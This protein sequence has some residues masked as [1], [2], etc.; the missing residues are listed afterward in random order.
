MQGEI[1]FGEIANTKQPA[2]ESGSYWRVLER[3]KFCV[4]VRADFAVQVD[5]FVLRGSPFHERR[6]LREINSERSL[7]RLAGQRKRGKPVALGSWAV[8]AIERRLIF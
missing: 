6:S 3:L 7:A 4:G 1:F 2:S 8:P 5:L